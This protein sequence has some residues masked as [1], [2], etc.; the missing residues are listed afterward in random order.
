MSDR[1]AAE[2]QDRVFA[3]LQDLRDSLSLLTRRVDRLS[4]LVEN[5]TASA[6]TSGF[7]SASFVS[8]PASSIAPI[9]QFPESVGGSEILGEGDL[10]L[11]WSER[12]EVAHCVGL[13]LRRSLEGG[14]RG[15]SG[16]SR[17]EE[18]SKFYIVC[19]DFEGRVFED[20]AKV[21]KNFTEVKRLCCRRS[22]WGQSVFVGL[23]T[24][25]EVEI[26]L[27]AGRFGSPSIR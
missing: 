10:G 1:A 7:G 24:A 15:S 18:A 2:F 27:R 25:H 22:D 6:G 20:P 26:A 5:R 17:I 23:P 4:G 9:A 8:S 11:G 12:E 16:R 21:L 19:R 3:E 14:R 13:W